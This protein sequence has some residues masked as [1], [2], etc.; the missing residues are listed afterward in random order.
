MTVAAGPG[1][2]R[3]AVAFIFITVTL[4]IVA[5][6]VI[7]PVWPN[8]VKGFLGGD[9]SRSAL[10]FGVFSTA[11]AAAQVICAPILGS[12]S[13]RYGRRPVILISCLGL[14]IDYVIMAT[15]PD[16]KWLFVGRLLAGITAANITTANAYIADV[17][18]P[19][20]RAAAYGV[21]SAAFGVGFILGP[22]LG[23]LLGQLGPR[24]P[25]WAAA[26]LTFANAAYGFL[27]LPESL[28][29]E[30]R[31]PFSLRLANPFAAIGMLASKGRLM[32]LAMVNFMARLV[33]ALFATVWALYVADRY[34]W[35][36]WMIGV[37]MTVVGAS[38]LVVSAGLVRPTVAWLGE[39]KTL[40]VGLLF[41]AAGFAALGW[42]SRGWAFLVAIF[43][44]CLWGLAGPCIQSLMT[45][46]VSDSEQGRL[47]GANTGLISIAGL[48]G[49]SLFAVTFAF[50]ATPAHKAQGL[51]G[52]PFFL[53]SA[54]ML[55]AVVM[56]WR[57]TRAPEAAAAAAR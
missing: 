39:R 26:G 14:A 17:T 54:L 13:D 1:R 8:L 25:F 9:T 23:G 36:P 57:A 28:A 51:I 29:P 10:A 56:A 7:G 46:L 37:S 20:K 6:G 27:V 19:E 49:P 16:L 43:V 44:L 31:S 3:A 12:L 40:A 11:F 55:A 52:L 50:A 38:S 5:N 2:R 42:A 22:M 32:G 33:N 48:I 24:L 4:D 21:L 18:P 41:A 34:G 35:G 15:A 53:A 45:R 30:N 47:Q